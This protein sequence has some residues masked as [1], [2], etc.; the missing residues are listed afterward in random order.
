MARNIIPD[1]RDP[2]RYA[3]SREFVMTTHGDFSSL[4]HC[5]KN[6]VYYWKGQNVDPSLNW[7]HKAFKTIVDALLLASDLETIGH[8]L[9]VKDE[10][11]SFISCAINLVMMIGH[12]RGAFNFPFSVEPGVNDVE[13]IVIMLRF[14]GRYSDTPPDLVSYWNG[15]YTSNG[16]LQ[17]QPIEDEGDEDMDEG[18]D[19]EEVEV[20]DD[21]ENKEDEDEDN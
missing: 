6:T 2:T 9:H 10:D 16:I 1:N 18:S 11:L 14:H 8:F 3:M 21:G 15:W 13:Q 17:F 12:E 5:F 19:G 4:L 20:I 7:K